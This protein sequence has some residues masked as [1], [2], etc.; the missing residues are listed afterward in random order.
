LFETEVPA[1]CQRSEK[2]LLLAMAEMYVQGMSTCEVR[3]ITEYLCG[4]GLQRRHGVGGD[5][6]DRTTKLEHAMNRALTEEYPR[7][8]LCLWVEAAD[9]IER[10]V[11]A[12]V[13]DG[14]ATLSGFREPEMETA[15]DPALTTQG[16][17][18][19]AWSEEMRLGAGVI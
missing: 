8:R 14:D 19:Q 7:R 4:H 10:E 15:R 18:S 1:C 13:D 5:Q 3:A 9:S 2:T 6:A 17:A 11:V 16:K 12:S